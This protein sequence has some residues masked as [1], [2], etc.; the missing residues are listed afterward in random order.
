MADLTRP[1]CEIN[2]SQMNNKYLIANKSREQSWR[3]H[4][5]AKRISHFSVALCVAAADYSAMSSRRPVSIPFPS[6]RALGRFAR[7]IPIPESALADSAKSISARARAEDRTRSDGA[8][9]ISSTHSNK[10][11]KTARGYIERAINSRCS[12][13]RP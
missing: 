6:H 2:Q 4:A 13:M 5:P 11:N 7:E 9:P 8:S 1:R 10:I 12:Q 3:A